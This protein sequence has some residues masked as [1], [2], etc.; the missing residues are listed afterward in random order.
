PVVRVEA[1]GVTP[2]GVAGVG[3]NKT[4]NGVAAADA[5]VC[6]GFADD[7]AAAVAAHEA[8]DPAPP[9]DGHLAGERSGDGAEIEA[10]QTA[11]KIAADDGAADDADILQGA[12]VAAGDADVVAAGDDRDV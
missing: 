5:R 2:E 6:I 9:D 4:G 7:A 11:D 12:V 1:V 3:A 8:A 10:D